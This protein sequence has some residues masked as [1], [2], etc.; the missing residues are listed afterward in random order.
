M[1]SLPYPRSHQ[2]IF[3]QK[4]LAE[5]SLPQIARMCTEVS[6]ARYSPTDFTDVHRLGGSGIPAI[7]TQ[8]LNYLPTEVSGRE[9]SPTEFTDFTEVYDARYS[10]TDCTDVHRL[11]GYGI[12][13]YPRSHQTIFPQKPQNPTQPN[14]LWASVK[15]VGGSS[16]PFVS[17]K[18]VNSVGG[19]QRVAWVWQD[20]IPSY[21]N[22]HRLH[23]CA[24]I[25]RQ[26]R[27]LKICEHL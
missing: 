13:P 22:S 1:A 3:P 5:K 14:H 23:G 27:N 25:R 2:T 15:S 19:L 26:K 6:G 24:Q 10:P 20:D 8:P 7:P 21:K 16:T 4:F 12:L 17:V 11:G 9:E 18:S